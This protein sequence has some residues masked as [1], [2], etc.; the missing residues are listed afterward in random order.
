VTMMPAISYDDAPVAVREDLAAAHRAAWDRLRCP[1]TWWTG[2]GRV[3]IAAETRAAATCALCRARKAA[4]SPSAVDGVHERVSGLPEPVV[5]AVHRIATDPG[6]LTERWYR[7]LVDQTLQDTDFVELVGVVITV[8]GIDTFARALGL[9]VPDLP[10]PQTGEPTRVRPSGASVVGHW[11]PS[12]P[13][14]PGSGAVPNIRRALSLVPAEARGFDELGAV[15]YLPLDDLMD[16]G[17]DR[18]LSRPQMELLA[19]RVSALNQCFY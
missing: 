14:E 11:V 19:A 8:V 12:I 16:F 18:A 17:R 15:M 7:E 2:R 10:E 1:G 4:V 9:P 3:E 5:D 13:P 6:R